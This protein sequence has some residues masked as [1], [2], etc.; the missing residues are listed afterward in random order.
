MQK[1]LII[2]TLFSTVFYSCSKEN[3]AEFEKKATSALE[4]T[5]S[6]STISGT[7]GLISIGIDAKGSK[8]GTMFYA[9]SNT[10]IAPPTDFSII[11]G[12][13]E[14]AVITG[15]IPITSTS[16]VHNTK[17]LIYSTRYYVYSVFRSVNDEVS[18]VGLDSII[19]MDISSP[20][21]MNTLSTP[22]H[23]STVDP[24]TSFELMFNEDVTIEA[25]A[26]INLFGFSSGEE[27][28]ISADKLTVEGNKV[29]V[30]ISEI[31]FAYEDSI[32]VKIPEGAFKDASGN[33]SLEITWDFDGDSFSV[34]DYYFNIRY[35]N[36]NDVM[37]DFLGL[38]DFDIYGNHGK[39]SDGQTEIV[40]KEGTNNTVILDNFYSAY[41]IPDKLE[42]EFDFNS[43]KLKFTQTE[44]SMYYNLDPND[45]DNRGLFYGDPTED[46]HHR[47][48]YIP[49]AL[50]HS[51][52]Y[53]RENNEFIVMYKLV[54]DYG[55][56]SLGVIDTAEQ[57]YSQVQDEEPTAKKAASVN[58]E[59]SSSVITP[60]RIDIRNLK[61]LL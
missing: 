41:G 19:A 57:I 2:I 37:S 46:H 44:S 1:I 6:E 7:G 35:E 17:T 60:I 4:V 16:T 20:F 27:Y 54:I 55:G 23:L 8:D 32:L 29:S 49:I 14:G 10:L 53:N 30:D 47:A 34:L 42:F 21:L 11:D 58:A 40:L 31:T 28:N 3:V 45:L 15:D 52:E 26:N 39:I 5:L 25:T 9:V 43:G 22:S 51:G 38:N 18:P 48:Y 13:V 50:E 24:N 12:N 61:L 36:A 56:S 33:P 59:T